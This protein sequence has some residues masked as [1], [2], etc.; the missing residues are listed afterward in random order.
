LSNA[1]RAR[2][3]AAAEAATKARSRLFVV[4]ALL[5]V[6]A[7]TGLV[8]RAYMESK[9]EE[10]RF[11]KEMRRRSEDSAREARRFN[12]ELKRIREGR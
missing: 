7:G 12:E 3:A 2:N 6:V 1:D 5:A 9:A 11:E 4:L 8:L 10:Q